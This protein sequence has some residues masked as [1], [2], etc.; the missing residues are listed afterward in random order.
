MY[1]NEPFEPEI[2]EQ[3][4]QDLRH[5]EAL[6]QPFCIIGMPD[7]TNLGKLCSK[8]LIQELNAKKIVSFYYSDF[9]PISIVK[10][11]N[12]IA[13]LI[14]IEIHIVKRLQNEH[15]LILITSNGIPKSPIGNNYLADKIA[16]FISSYKTELIISIT[17]IPI[18]HP[19]QAPRNYLAYTSDKLLQIFKIDKK[20]YQNTNL[21]LQ[22]LQKGIITGLNGLIIGYAESLYN[23]I[24]GI[25]LSETD[26]SKETDYLAIKAILD[27][28]NEIFDLQISYKSLTLKSSQIFKKEQKTPASKEEI[29][30]KIRKRIQT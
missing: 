30:K 3:Y 6:N 25:L 17:G 11:Q 23:V 13:E 18:P 20:K 7:L 5:L 16:E 15:D 14:N 19:S 21:R 10:K 24:G 9:D 28:L 12:Q 8:C 27:V 4:F 1:I 26:N 29:L 22:P 2:F